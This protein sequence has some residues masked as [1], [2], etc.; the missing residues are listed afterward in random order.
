MTAI[1]YQRTAIHYQWAAIQYQR[2][3]IQYQRAATKAVDLEIYM[4][5]VLEILDNRWQGKNC[6]LN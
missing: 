6:R 1:K 4:T 3:A 5:N 2:A